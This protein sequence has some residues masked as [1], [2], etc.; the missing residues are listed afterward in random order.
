N[1]D[2][3][4]LLGAIQQGL[5]DPA[6]NLWLRLALLGLGSAAAIFLVV[7]W[8]L[9]VQVGVLE[10]APPLRSLGRSWHLGGRNFWRP[11]GVVLLGMLPLTL[12]S[13]GT[14]VAQFFN[15]TPSA[16]GRVAALAL[17]RGVGLIV[18]LLLLPWALALLTLYYY[19]LR[20]RRDGPAPE[21]EG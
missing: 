15:L 5:A 19:D 11:L 4:G 12:L 20:L 17:A 14:L 21:A 6:Q 7:R 9:M 3:G 18:R 1:A 2:S 13:N 10:D 8:S 16:E